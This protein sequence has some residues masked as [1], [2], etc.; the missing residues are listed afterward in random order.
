MLINTGR[1]L[2]G[3]FLRVFAAK[4]EQTHQPLVSQGDELIC[5]KR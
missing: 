4:M 1:N 2:K 3:Y 5:I